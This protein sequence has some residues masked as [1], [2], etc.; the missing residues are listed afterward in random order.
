MPKLDEEQL[1]AVSEI[2]S[3][4]FVDD[5]IKIVAH[6]DATGKLDEFLKITDLKSEVRKELDRNLIPTK[7][8]LVVGNGLAKESEYRQQ[9]KNGGISPEN[10]EFYLDF[11]DGAKIDF[12]K[13]K[14]NPEYG[15]IIVGA[16][17]HVG[18]SKGNY[19]SVIEYIEN[20]P[21]FP[22]VVRGNDGGKLKLSVNGFYTAVLELFT[23]GALAVNG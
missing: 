19:S 3:N 9:C 17:P 2:I 8:V 1:L 10:F 16:M 14:D 12:D 23:S 13:Y 11:E 6:L 18:V 20:E 5:P 15:G 7:K 22:K 21:G 4:A